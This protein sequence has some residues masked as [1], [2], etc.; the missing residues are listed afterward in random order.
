MKKK[1]VALLI[2]SLI[3][4]T[5]ACGTDKTTAGNEPDKQAEIKPDNPNAPDGPE[6]DSS[7]SDAIN[8]PDPGEETEASSISADSVQQQVD[9]RAVPTSEGYVC[10]F[11]TNNSDTIIDE[12]DLQIL[13]KDESG[14]TIDI[15]EDGHDMVLP[16]STVV[17]RMDAPDTY[18]SLEPSATVELGV[19]PNYENQAAD[20]EVDTNEGDDCVIVEIKNKGGVDIEEI[21]YIL[22]F[23]KGDAVSFVTY[24]EDV[25]DVKAG[26]SITEKVETYGRDYDKYETYINQAHTFGL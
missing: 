17:S 10:A 19:N 18:T 8:A 14:T 3:I 20:V 4:S 22:V 9:V 25:R 13:Y 2:A 7:T 16:G 1:I 23:Y 5:T 24:P 26:D 6:T 21:E 11:I 12:L 15:A